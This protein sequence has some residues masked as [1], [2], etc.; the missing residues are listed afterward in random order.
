MNILQNMRIPK[1]DT[2]I[3]HTNSFRDATRNYFPSALSA[4]AILPEIWKVLKIIIYYV[5]GTQNKK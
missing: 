1:R 3:K 4:V 5:Q 2:Y